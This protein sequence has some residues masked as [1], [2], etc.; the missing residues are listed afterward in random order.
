M[1]IIPRGRGHGSPAKLRRSCVSILDWIFGF[2]ESGN[3][4]HDPAQGTGIEQLSVQQLSLPHPRIPAVDPLYTSR[5]ELWYQGPT[6][7]PEVLSRGLCHTFRMC[8]FVSKRKR[9]YSNNIDI[10]F[11]CGCVANNFWSKTRCDAPFVFKPPSM[12]CKRKFHS[13]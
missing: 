10:A 7:T 8:R 13:T 2:A 3:V 11:L 6:P 12:W 1:A 4:A 9:K 5:A